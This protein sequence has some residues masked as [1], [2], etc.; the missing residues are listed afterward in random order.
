MKCNGLRLLSFLRSV[1]GRLSIFSLPPL[2]SRVREAPKPRSQC[3]RQGFVVA[4]VPSSSL[5]GDTHG[6]SSRPCRPFHQATT[7]ALYNIKADIIALTSLRWRCGSSSFDLLYK[8][9]R[10][11]NGRGAQITVGQRSIPTTSFAR[12]ISPSSTMC[13]PST[14]P[15]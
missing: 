11:A 1:S 6:S 12:R 10:F 2:V 4:P 15:S 8:N 5:H 7:R 9:D 14:P 3:D 13:A